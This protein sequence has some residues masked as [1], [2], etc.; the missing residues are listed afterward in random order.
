MNGFLAI[1]SAG[2]LLF[3]SVAVG[4]EVP[5]DIA[6]FKSIALPFF[7]THCIRCHGPEKSKGNL[8]LDTE[9]KNNFLNPVEVAHWKEIIDAIHAH[10]MPPE[11]EPQ[12]EVEEAVRFADWATQ[13]LAH[14]EIARRS[15]RPVLRRINRAEY[16]N[17]LL[18]LI[19]VQID[20]EVL[21]ADP[22]SGGFDN[23]GAALTISPLHLEV[24]FQ[25][26]RQAL[27]KATATGPQPPTTL[28]R[29]EPEESQSGD[30]TRVERDKH[31]IIV[32][33]GESQKK[34]GY[35]ILRTSAWNKNLNIRDFA[36][37]HP[38]QYIIRIKAGGVIPPREE[39]MEAVHKLVPADRL[40]EETLHHF[41]H[42]SHYNYGAPRL[43]VI[44]SLGGQP[45]PVGEFDIDSVMPEAKVYEIIAPFTTERAGFTFEYA[46]S[47]P[48]ELENFTIQGKDEFPRPEAWI[49]WVELEG[50]IHPQWPPASQK[51]LYP[52]YPEALDK[53][54]PVPYANRVLAAFMRRA[55]RRP[56]SAEEVQAKM[57]LF[58]AEQAAAGDFFAAME[59][60]LLSTLT[61]PH[62]LYLVESDLQS[63]DA[64]N[65]SLSAHE[66][67]A[68]LSYFLW[69][70]TPDGELMKLA[71]G[72][73]LT[74]PAV[75]RSQVDR[76]LAHP[77]SARFSSN[78][79]GQ[80]LE[81]R[82]IGANPPAPDLFREYDRHLETSIAKESIAFFDEILHQNLS[83]LNLI[84]SDFVTINERLAR[85]YGIEGVRGDHFRR[86]SV[87]K[88]I[89][90]GGIVTQAS[91]LSIT[92]N[93][94][95]TSPVVRGT[96]I[97]KNLLGSDPGLPVANVG[98]IAPSVPGIQ[99]AT[100]RQRLQIH[101]ELPQCAR[102]HDKIDPLGFALENFDASGK[103]REREGFGYQ[104]R[105]GS[106][107]PLIDAS[108]KMPDGSEFVG[109]AGLQQQMLEKEDLF[110]RCLTEKLFT[111]ALGRELGFSDAAVVQE[112]LAHMKRN[113]YSLRS[114]IHSII[115]SK[116][117]TTR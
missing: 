97:L 49:D 3:L 28:W 112:S 56:V 92:S 10:Q 59:G 15:D 46:Y 43:K 87:P 105:I 33:A 107:D 84:R 66:L 20:P 8:R 50:P 104:G 86:V 39:V 102:C 47:I 45:S 34:D 69:S 38:G 77:Y 12:P 114:L 91:I 44:T 95:R 74:D 16:T 67:A 58:D 35:T 13:Q 70:T 24:Y 6:G 21:P 94:T 40:N 61:S 30:R 99:K 57:A 65:R 63:G 22:A 85:F 36:V 90:R 108:A 37:A 55:W 101:R 88:D 17:T 79:A 106:D 51:L 32:N 110:L 54:G 71:S 29:F 23:I 75:L 1:I 80:W 41:K 76:M 62:F 7:E 14:A 96:W 73:K 26:A 89:Q 116:P 4:E 52:E 68:R 31:R 27:A 115:T 11:D 83:A 25:A 42:S 117:F 113:G 19:G 78:F 9:I 72:G 82:K 98:D 81:L 100:V 48:R 53:E 18:D 2:T 103:W 60:P 111:Y 93:G 5:T 109:L 64:A